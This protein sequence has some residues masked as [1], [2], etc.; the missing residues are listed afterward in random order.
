MILSNGKALSM[1]GI[2]AVMT[3]LRRTRLHSTLS[4]EKVAQR[5][6]ESIPFRSSLFRAILALSDWGSNLTGTWGHETFW[7][8]KDAFGT[9]AYLP[10]GKGTILSSEPGSVIEVVFFAPFS[11]VILVISA[12]GAYW[13]VAGRDPAFLTVVIWFW[14]LIHLVGILMFNRQATKIEQAL[15]QIIGSKDT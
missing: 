5:L 12:L 3:P 11:I 1:N 14:A 6:Q 4:P 8:M 13:A 10:F 2:A 7:I 9:N 15:E